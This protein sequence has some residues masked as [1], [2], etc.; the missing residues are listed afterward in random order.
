MV[1]H[2]PKSPTPCP[3]RGGLGTAQ[4]MSPG[5]FCVFTLTDPACDPHGDL[6]GTGTWERWSAGPRVSLQETPST[7]PPLGSTQDVPGW[8][9]WGKAFP[10]HPWSAPTLAADRGSVLEVSLEG[11]L[12][13]EGAANRLLVGVEARSLVGVQGPRG[14]AP[15][16]A[17]SARGDM[18]FYHAA[19]GK[20]DSLKQLSL[21]S[22][23]GVLLSREFSDT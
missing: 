3:P 6:P 15:S 8:E 10:Q 4:A 2:W 19:S 18:W 14:D 23:L 9:G 17:S 20:L 1:Q 16:W 12:R 11:R 21:Y 13:T 7:S 22:Q 5:S